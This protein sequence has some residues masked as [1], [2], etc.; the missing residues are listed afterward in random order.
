MLMMAQKR[1]ES[2]IYW[3]IVDVIGIELYY[4]RDV[5]FISLLYVVLLVIA[6]NGFISWNRISRQDEATSPLETAPLET[7][8]ST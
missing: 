8:P 7:A 2:W 6:I 5:A 3:I 1:T 4:S